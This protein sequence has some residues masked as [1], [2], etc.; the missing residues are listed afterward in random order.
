MLF[1]SYHCQRFITISK[2]PH[3]HR[4]V[5][6]CKTLHSVWDYEPTGNVAWRCAAY[7][8][9][10]QHTLAAVELL[11]SVFVPYLAATSGSSVTLILR[12]VKYGDLSPI[13]W[14]A[15]CTRLS[16]RL[17]CAII[18]IPIILG[19]TPSCLPISG[20]PG[21]LNISSSASNIIPATLKPVWSSISRMH[22]GLVTL[23]SV[24]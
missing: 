10:H 22:V 24:R 2:S 8:A 20:Q 1:S 11:Q 15:Q 5:Y 6:P 12:S 9:Q 4:Q 23:I 14:L 13:T 21:Q 19:L 16:P 7:I 18:K 17:P 3:Q